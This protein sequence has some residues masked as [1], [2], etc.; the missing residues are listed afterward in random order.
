MTPPYPVALVGV[1]KIARD[2]HIPA[3][4]ADPDFTLVAGVSRHA[5][6]DGVPN[7]ADLDSFLADGPPAVVALCVPPEARTAMALKALAAGRD[8]LLEKPPAA[9]LGEVELMVEAAR[10]RDAVL[11]ATWHSRFAPAVAE[12]KAW[13]ASRKPRS[14]SIVWKEDVRRWHPNQAWIWQ[15]GGF[16]VFDPGINALSVLTEILPG[17]FVVDKARLVVPENC[18][19]PIA[20]DFALTAAQGFPVGVELDWRQEG[21][22][23]WDIIVE[24]DDG[25]LELSEGGAAMQ[26]DGRNVARAPERE[27]PLIYRRFA[28]LLRARES[29]VDASPLRI[30]ADAVLVARRE[31][32]EPFFD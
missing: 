6:I 2:Q 29:E 22:Q 7:F 30:I 13:L 26:V 11:F 24:T 28:G 10:A 14:V 3:I 18:E 8:V 4:A 32:T 15:A 9:T 27:Y 31:T 25:R 21:P 23:S 1:G 12:A 5:T 20:A 17:P 16:G 19:T